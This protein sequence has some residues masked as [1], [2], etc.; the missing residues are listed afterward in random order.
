MQTAPS[1]LATA[2][3]C[4][5]VR[6]L[7]LPSSQYALADLCAVSRADITLAELMVCHIERVIANE[8]ASLQTPSGTPPAS[9]PNSPYQSPE[10]SVSHVTKTPSYCSTPEAPVKPKIGPRT[11]DYPYPECDG[12]PEESPRSLVSPCVSPGTPEQEFQ[13][14]DMESDYITPTAG[15]YISPQCMPNYCSDDKNHQSISPKSPVKHVTIPSSLFPKEMEAEIQVSVDDPN[16]SASLGIVPLANNN[17]QGTNAKH[18]GKC[19]N[20]PTDVQNVEF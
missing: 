16:R 10:A 6:G 1:L 17:S 8:T 2:C 7:N 11:P 9:N 18:S 19:G 4:A 20:T 12:T 13:P 5:A 14:T 15:D 3:V